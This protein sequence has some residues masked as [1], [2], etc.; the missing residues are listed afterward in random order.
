LLRKVTPGTSSRLAT[1]DHDETYG[2]HI[3]KRILRA[4]DVAT[5]VDLG[6]GNGDDL[7]I[8]KKR[9]P[10]ARCI[11]VDHGEGNRD[12]LSARN[13][14]ALS[15]DIERQ[16]LPFESGSIDLIIANQ[17]LEHT[18]EV[19]WIH[20]EIFRC[21]RIG[22]LLY[23]GVPNVLSLHNR[24]LGLFG[25]HP[26]SAK[27]ISAHVRVF[28]K[29]DTFLFYREVAGSFGAV[30]GF[31]G[32][33]FYPFPRIIARPLASLFPAWAFSIFFLIRKTKPY[34]GQFMRWLSA[35]GL[36]TNFYAG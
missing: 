2:R 24:I 26:T 6:C 20:H 9:F 4:L 17:V 34:D 11:G 21:L 28:S 16:P 12:A 23:L 3:L 31:Y 14:E 36:E 27:L 18:K 29:Q 19:F 22:G 5:C 7:A 15:V 32:S 1:V 8:V 10:G 35:A 30:E 13:L 25:V 33:Q